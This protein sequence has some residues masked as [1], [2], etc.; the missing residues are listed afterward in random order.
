MV[1][2]PS[3][4]GES[5][6]FAHNEHVQHLTWQLSTNVLVFLVVR[7]R[8]KGATVLFTLAPFCQELSDGGSVNNILMSFIWDTRNRL[9]GGS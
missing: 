9:D 8:E 4:G 7:T 5:L 1:S 2:L 3:R 6:Y